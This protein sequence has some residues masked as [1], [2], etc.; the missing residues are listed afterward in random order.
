MKI[1]PRLRAASALAAALLVTGSCAAPEPP[2]AAAPTSAQAAPP[3]APAPMESPTSTGILSEEAFKALHELR[4]DKAP[5]ARGQMIDI[6]STSARAYLSLPKDAKPKLPA[7]VVIHEWWGL[8][9]HIK[10]WSD[11]L[12]DDGYAALAVDLYGGKVATNPDEA[13]ATMKAVD[14]QAAIQ[15]LRAAHRFLTTDPRIMAS[16][17]GSIGWCFGGGF[18]LQLALNEPELDAAVIY[19]GRLVADPQ[20]LKAIRA[21]ILGIFGNQDKGIPPSAVDEFDK[22]LGEAGVAH[23][24]RRYEADHAFANPSGQ[25]YNTTAAADAWEHVRKFLAQKLKG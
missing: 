25:R 13:M 12:A 5:P 7:V 6:P 15:T 23:E 3:P 19:Y 10:H 20:K 11:R 24:I 9:D 8:N 1:L 14:P 4:S 22:A 2:K 18:S 16:R 17:T 21:P